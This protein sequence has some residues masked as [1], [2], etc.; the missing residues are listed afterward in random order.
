MTLK[1]YIESLKIGIE[2][3]YEIVNEAIN[4]GGIELEAQLKNR[5]FNE[6]VDIL[7]TDFGGYS[8]AYK[9]FR[10]KVGRDAT[11]KNLQL[12][13][14]MRLGI[15]YYEED[16]AIK[17]QDEKDAIKGRSAE[18]YQKQRIFEASEEEATLALDT[19]DL[20]FNERISEQF[21]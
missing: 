3:F 8:E 2:Q 11:N 10:L 7:G 18:I 13:D 17:F 1:E 19:I 4:A 9:A 21:E 15:K 5:I 6:N 14:R 12:T 16:L 20:V